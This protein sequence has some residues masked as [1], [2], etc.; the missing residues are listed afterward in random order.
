MGRIG[1][2]DKKEGSLEI[3][4]IDESDVPALIHEQFSILSE[5][6]SNLEIARKK[7]DEVNKKAIESQEKGVHLF[8][9]KNSIEDLQAN[10]VALSESNRINMDLQEKSLLFQKKLTE[11]MQ[12][13]LGLGVANITMNRCV[14]KELMMRLDK[15]SEEEIDDMTRKEILNVVKQLKAQEDIY[16]KTMEITQRVKEHNNKIIDL[17]NEA[18]MNNE[19]IIQQQEENTELKKVLESYENKQQKQNKLLIIFGVV[20]AIS[21]IIG[22]I[23]IILLIV[24]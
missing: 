6:I 18:I 14:V 20:A 15:A 2:E 7:A 23:S 4:K 13:L 5:Y 24:K 9:M 21:L 3:V 19:R 12:Y 16:N 22:I 8:K 17:E 11:I 10:Q 1:M